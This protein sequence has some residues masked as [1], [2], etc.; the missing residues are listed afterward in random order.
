[1]KIKS[2]NLIEKILIFAK[3]ALL[4]FLLIIVLIIIVA[5]YLVLIKPTELTYNYSIVVNFDGDDVKFQL[6]E[7]FRCISRCDTVGKSDTLFLK[8]YLTT[9]A[10][11]FLTEKPTQIN[12]KRKN[13]NYILLNNQ[14]ITIDS[15]VLNRNIQVSRI[16]FSS[17]QDSIKTRINRSDYPS[18][19]E[20]Q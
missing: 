18:V 2:N 9:I 15:L 6:V 11:F 16:P 5:Y 13:Y 4:K 1:M 10:N 17:K 8:I 19:I 14:I 20:N 3:R 7:S 12:F